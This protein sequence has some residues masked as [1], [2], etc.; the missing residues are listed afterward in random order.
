METTT[1][2][3]TRVVRGAIRFQFLVIHSLWPWSS[4]YMYQTSYTSLLS[5]AEMTQT[6]FTSLLSCAEV[7]QTSYTS[8]LSC[9]PKSVNFT[10]VAYFTCSWVHCCLIKFYF[11]TGTGM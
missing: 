3:E 9:D 11:K 10:W 8:L 7:T 2:S 5:C 4:I 6:G 1:S